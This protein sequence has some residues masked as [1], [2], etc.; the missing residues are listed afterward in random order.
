MGA[1]PFEI[2]IDGTGHPYTRKPWDTK[3]KFILWCLIGLVTLTIHL[4]IGWTMATYIQNNVANKEPITFGQTFWQG[5]NK[6]F[7]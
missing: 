1:G 6:F 2:E 3:K 5:P 7:A 4:N